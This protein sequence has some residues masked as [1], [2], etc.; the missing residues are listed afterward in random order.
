MLAKPPPFLPEEIQTVSDLLQYRASET[1]DRLAYEFLTDGDQERETITYGQLARQAR[2]FAMSLGQ[3]CQPGDRV[4]ILQPPGLGYLTTFFGCLL[5]GF[6]A[7]PAYPPRKNRSVDRILSIL[8]DATPKVAVTTQAI[9]KILKP[10]I[11]ELPEL[12]KVNWVLSDRLSNES[13]EQPENI[14]AATEIAF[15]Q[16]TSGSTGNP[17]GVMVSHR[18]I[19][20]NVG[21]MHHY[22]GG[23]HESWG[24][25]WLPPYHDMGLIAGIIEP[26]YSGFPVTL[27]SPFHFL[28][29]PFRWLETISSR[30][31][32]MSGAPNFAYD[33]CIKK[34]TDEQRSKLDL[35]SWQ[36]A[37]NGAEPIQADVLE[38]FS[39]TFES[40]GFEKQSFYPCYGMAEATLMVSWSQKKHRPLTKSFPE[41]SP[42]VLVS[43]GQSLNDQTVKIVDPQTGILCNEGIEGE[44]WVSGQSISSGYWQQPDL[45]Q[46]IFEA[47]LANDSDQS[48]LRT[49]D[50]G[51]LHQEELFV[52]GRLKD[53]I[54]LNGVNYYPQ[55][56]EKAIENSHEAIQPFGVAVVSTS[57]PEKLIVIAEIQRHYI[58]KTDILK[59]VIQQIRKDI[60]QAFQLVTH[61]IV[62]IK[63]GQLPKTS[64]GKVQRNA[65]KEK[66]R[67]QELPA[68]LESHL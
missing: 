9:L 38:E 14:T 18:N 13:P 57:S 52:T 63:P 42:N 56:L 39:Q 51:I 32:N 53:L 59:S 17:K 45:N 58:R 12:R 8:K 65:C 46:K 35:S 54:I 3:W 16:Y 43:S 31:A 62:L 66:F 55:D 47:H 15:L 5:G 40:V 44:I 41:I 4:L 1:P 2:A 24:V 37:F 30:K 7:V 19:L 60:S 6:I 28:Q 10:R 11:I 50:L 23:N 64:S 61:H 27:M 26:L 48:F 33:L 22:V 36:I 49:G 21:W 67:C 68:I 25:S 29:K 34:I 20:H